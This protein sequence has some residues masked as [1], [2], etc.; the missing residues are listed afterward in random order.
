MKGTNSARIIDYDMEMTIK[1]ADCAGSVAGS[2]PLESFLGM[3]GD[4]AFFVAKRATGSDKVL[5]EI[6]PL[7]SDQAA[8]TQRSWRLASELDN[9]NLMRLY[10]TGE[11][12]VDEMP[13][14]YAVLPLPDDD[15]GEILGTR[16]L[17]VDEAR[18]MVEGAAGALAYLHGRDLRHGAVIPSNLFV[19]GDE[20]KLG[21][22]TITPASS[23]DRAEDL[24]QLGGTIIESLTGSR[25]PANAR[26]L[27]AP[28]A[29][30]AQGCLESAGGEWTADRVRR[31][32][33]G[34][35][36]TPVP[37]PPASRR[38]HWPLAAAAGVAVIALLGYWL[39]R[40]AHNEPAAPP[41][42]PPRPPVEVALPPPTPKPSPL[43]EKPQ[44]VPPRRIEQ[45]ADRLAPTEAQPPG[46]WA[47]IAATYTNF[48]AARK[49]AA[50][51]QS[52]LDDSQTHVFPAEGQG[53]KYYVVLGSGL[54]Q[55]QAER[56]R[57][58]AIRSGAPADSYVTKLRE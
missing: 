19:T 12:E 32:L 43:P 17:S 6:I 51:I 52:A 53:A 50:K 1:W 26:E 25:D 47:V 27:P 22:D 46:S 3:R 29:E 40:P 38:R 57:D 11:T 45:Q 56:L 4:L 8:A 14:A 7:N 20:V 58:R 39:T 55:L 35:H 5:I 42:S 10:E 48:E 16:K 37:A 24:R 9:P 34:E 21:T 18:V 36:P 33:N 2:W 23:Q 30:I 28:F 41:A 44:R 54:T 15:I 13:A 49:R 31:V